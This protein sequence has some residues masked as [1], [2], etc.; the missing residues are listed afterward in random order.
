MTDDVTYVED[1]SVSNDDESDNNG[2]P[3]VKRKRSDQNINNTYL[4]S[5]NMFL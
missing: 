3:K 5:R 4:I 2:E 1:F